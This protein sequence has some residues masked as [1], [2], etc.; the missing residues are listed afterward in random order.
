MAMSIRNRFGRTF[1]GPREVLDPSVWSTDPERK[2]LWTCAASGEK[3]V[4]VITC[5]DFCRDLQKMEATV[6][7]VKRFKN[8]EA[9]KRNH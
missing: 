4:K 2:I 1:D 9:I 5:L 6:V 7:H 8:S 3:L